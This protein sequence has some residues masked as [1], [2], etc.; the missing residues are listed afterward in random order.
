MTNTPPRRPA[1]ALQEH[2]DTAITNALNETEGGGIVTASLT[3]VSYVDTDGRT[4][5]M[6]SCAPGQRIIT[7]LGLLRFATLGV[8]ADATD[9]FRD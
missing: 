1:E 8:E 5:W 2:V 4:S 3:V 9:M 7:T 6:L